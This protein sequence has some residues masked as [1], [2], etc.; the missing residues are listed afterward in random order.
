MKKSFLYQL[1]EGWLGKGLLTSTGSK[2]Q[3]RR[4]L[5]TQAFHFNIL[6][7]FVRVFNEET[8]H[9]VERIEEINLIGE[10][11]EGISILPLV[12]HLTL[13]SVTG[14]FYCL[15]RVVVNQNCCRNIFRS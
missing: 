3:S 14:W 10:N 9:L 13:Q 12:T 1:L 8:A 2:W 7:K 5:L 11:G 6:Q 4:K 15:E